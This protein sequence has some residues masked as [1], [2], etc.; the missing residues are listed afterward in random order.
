[1]YLKNIPKPSNLILTTVKVFFIFSNTF[2]IKLN[3]FYIKGL[4]DFYS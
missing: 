3:I 4:K 1:M 2:H